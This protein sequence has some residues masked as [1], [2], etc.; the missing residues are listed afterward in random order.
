MFQ[1]ALVEATDQISL[2][3]LSSK[4]IS[5]RSWYSFGGKMSDK[6]LEQRI[7]IEFCVKTGKSASEMLTV[8]TL[9]Y[10]EY[11]MKKYGVFLMT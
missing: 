2:S 3:F 10:G 4:G 9:V 11:D 1:L 8:L 7:N 5:T 6:N